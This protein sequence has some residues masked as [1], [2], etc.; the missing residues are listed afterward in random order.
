MFFEAQDDEQK[1]KYVNFLSIIGSLSNLFSESL[2]PYL[3]YRIAEKIFCRAF[4]AEDLS[5]SDV[6]A[7][8]KKG[9]RG[10]GLKTFISGNNRTFQKIAEFNKQSPLYQSLT[11]KKLAVKISELR[12]LRIEFTENT[13]GIKNSIYH[14]VLRDKEKF[15]IFEEPMDRIDISNIGDVVENKNS[16]AFNDGKN[17]Y[18]FL[19]SKSTLTKRFVT[20]LIICEFDVEILKDPF[21]A[22]EQLLT[23]EV[24]PFD[25]EAR[26]KETIYLPLYGRNQIVYKRSGLNQWN[27]RGR[28]RHENEVYIRIPAE[29]HEYY[30]DFFPDR[31]IPFNLVLPNGKGIRS[32]ICQDLGKALMSYSNREL[33]KWILRDV[34][35]LRE[36]DL[37]TYEKLQIFGIDSV[38]IDKISDVEFEINFAELGS[39]EQFRGAFIS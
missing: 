16:I 22:L 8:A 38:R 26:I 35:R 19:L 11:A 5:R 12:N 17:D 21:K 1:Q 31:E 27:A 6:S 4:N 3:Y 23:Y 36:G 34:L 30:P 32:K 2:T 33:G 20:D 29:I 25:K 7:D 10:I 13:H 14:C 9:D 18:S 28:P 39:Y 15:L 24:L 37:A